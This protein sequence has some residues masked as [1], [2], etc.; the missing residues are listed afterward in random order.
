MAP[1][2]VEKMRRCSDIV[3]EFR[4]YVCDACHHLH[5]A[6]VCCKGKFCSTC[7]K[8]ESLRW[9]EVIE[10][11]IYLA[12]RRQVIFVIDEE[13]QVKKEKVVEHENN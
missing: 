3:H 2:E 12:I 9:S 10:D 6:P 1:N 8:G 11:D 13:S 7:S 5:K 4:A